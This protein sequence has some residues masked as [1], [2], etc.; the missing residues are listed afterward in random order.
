MLDVTQ[1][2]T[3]VKRFAY[4][5]ISHDNLCAFDFLKY[6]PNYWGMFNVHAENLLQISVQRNDHVL[7]MTI[8][9]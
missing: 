3:P 8:I 7:H 4:H 2:I 1:F 6:G 9:L 5:S